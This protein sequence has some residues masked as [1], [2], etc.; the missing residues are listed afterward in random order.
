[1]YKR[2]VY[3]PSRDII[4]HA[5]KGKGVYKN[6]LPWVLTQELDVLTYV[7]DRK[8]KDTPYATEIEQW[9]YDK[10]NELGL[11][12]VQ[13]IAGAGSVLNAILVLENS[14][15]CMLKLPKKES[16]GGSV[17]DYAATA[18]MFQEFNLPA[19]NYEGGT[20]DLNRE[21]DAFMN[22]QGIFFS[23]MLK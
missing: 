18:C 13:E 2:Q 16:G 14:P 20:L 15:A 7:T 1:M 8:L 9:L 5:I 19:T 10:A 23:S 6:N 4:Y 12:R 17:W 11:L 22:H 3:D 21:A